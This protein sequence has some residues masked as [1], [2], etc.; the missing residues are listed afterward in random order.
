MLNLEGLF[1]RPDIFNTMPENSQL[2]PLSS[3][4]RCSIE[5]LATEASQRSASQEGKA[6]IYD[7]CK[8]RL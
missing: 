6:Y 5:Q 1:L 3:A 2:R 4:L 7:R 8:W